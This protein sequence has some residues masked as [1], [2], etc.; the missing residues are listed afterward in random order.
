MLNAVNFFHFQLD[1]SFDHIFAEYAACSQVLVVSFQAVQSFAQRTTNLWNLGC[2]FSWQI[3]QIF[4][5]CIARVDLVLNAVQA[6]HQQSCESQVWVSDRV[7]ETC[8]DTLAFWRRNV[9]NTDRSRTVTGRVSQHNRSFEAWDQTLV[10]V[11][12][13]VGERIQGLSVLDHTTDVE[14]SRFRQTGIAVARELVHTVFPVRHVYVHT[15]TVVTTD[16][17]R[18]ER[19]GFTVSSSNVM[20]NVFQHLHFVSFL[21]QSVELNT[22]FVLS[23]VR[24]F[25]VMNF[26][27]QTNGFQCVTHGSTDV[28]VAVYW[29]NR[30]VT[31]F[32]AWTVTQV[33]A[34]HNRFGVPCSFGRVDF[35]EAAGHVRA[36]ANIVKHEEFWFWTKECS[37]TQTSGLQ[38]LFSTQCYRAWVA[39]VAL[40]SGRL[41]DVATQY[42]SGVFGEWI[43]EAGAVI[44]T[45]DH[46]GFVNAFPAS[47]RRT[48]EHLSGFEEVFVYI[49]RRNSNVLLF[50]LEIG[51]AQIN[52]LHIVF[53]D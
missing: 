13:W 11:S 5:R 1:V 40:H 19:S 10:R 53:F 18:H 15:G 22:D 44:R 7:R 8:F 30:E 47:N 25:V 28:V 41:D 14:Q 6:S 17:L 48:V 23:G 43:Q 46:V 24:H 42:Q 2:F 37:V 34:F 52:P 29:W 32:N 12:T 21:N 50:T 27:V 26:N 4:I 20:N 31:A 49:T 16:W 35:A 38:V 36:P 3:V 51:K 9:R 39:V 45:Q 33:A